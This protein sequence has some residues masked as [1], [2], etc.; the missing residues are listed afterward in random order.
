MPIEALT[1]DAASVAAPTGGSK[2]NSKAL[3]RMTE[4]D[5]FVRSCTPGTVRALLVTKA[6]DDKSD[7]AG[8]TARGLKNSV[9]RAMKR[10]K[11]DPEKDFQM[12]EGIY[13]PDPEKPDEKKPYLFV[14]SRREPAPEPPAEPGAEPSPTD[15]PAEPGGDTENAP[16]DPATD[17]PGAN[18]PAEAVKEPAKKK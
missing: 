15:P 8:E 2:T 18:T 11:F 3:S 4:Y 14:K 13:A 1:L 16:T 6:A 7:A 9:T 17:P 5:E 12:W 10:L